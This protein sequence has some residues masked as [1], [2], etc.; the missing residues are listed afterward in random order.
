VRQDAA[1]R[2][3][4]TRDGTAGPTGEGGFRA[5]PSRYHLYVSLACPW[6]SRAII[7]RKLKQVEHFISMSL[8]DPYMGDQGWAFAAPD[9]SLRP[10]STPDHLFGARYLHEIRASE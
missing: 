7:F 5:A 4:I 1:F 9:G 3:W 2:N 10:G 8:V 6:A